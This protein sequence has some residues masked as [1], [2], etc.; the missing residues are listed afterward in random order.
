MVPLWTTQTYSERESSHLEKVM[1]QRV[2]GSKSLL[3]Y[4]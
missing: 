4:C 3:G 2:E 1:L